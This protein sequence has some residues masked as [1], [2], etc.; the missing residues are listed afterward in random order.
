MLLSWNTLASRKII[1]A[2]IVIK[3]NTKLKI[4]VKYSLTD[5]PKKL[6]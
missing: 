5:K 6:N 4:R 1:Y 3:C 2:G